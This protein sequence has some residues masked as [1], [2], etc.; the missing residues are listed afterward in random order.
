MF[1][2]IEPRLQAVKYVRA[3]MS[4]LPKRNG[5]TIAEWAGDHSPDA[6]QRLSRS[7]IRFRAVSWYFAA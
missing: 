1:A 4:D 6:T 7:E 2:R 3:L 5:W